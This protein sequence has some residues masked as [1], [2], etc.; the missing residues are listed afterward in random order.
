MIPVHVRRTVN[1]TADKLWPVLGTF[2]RLPEWFPGIAAF[3]CEG[4]AVGHHRTI[5]IGPFN[6]KQQL[7]KQ[8]DMTYQ[9]VYQVLE[10]PGISQ[11]T[12]FMVTISLCDIT[13][14]G[15]TIDWKAVLGNL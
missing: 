10:G 15:C 13:E 3:E 8:D 11:A 6:I 9:T 5:T 12:G 1:I 2:S 7:L 4:D 14:K